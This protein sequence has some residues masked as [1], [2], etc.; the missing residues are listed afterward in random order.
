MDNN[1]GR[2]LFHSCVEVIVFSRG[3]YLDT[4]GAEVSSSCENP[5]GNIVNIKM[6]K[7]KAT[8]NDRRIGTY[9]LNYSVGVDVMRD[10]V[11][12][13]IFLEVI[14]Q[15]GAWFMMIDYTTGEEL[16]FQG[17]AKVVDYLAEHP[18]QFELLKEQVNEVSK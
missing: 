5:I 13:A 11:D 14:R 12:M 17:K 1:L 18:E 16:K 10:T 15:A 2:Q 9:T 7:N 4:K 3:S 8:K 6:E